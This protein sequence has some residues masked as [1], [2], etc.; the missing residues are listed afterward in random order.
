[1]VRPQWEVSTVAYHK[2]AVTRVVTQHVVDLR[3]RPPIIAYSMLVG[4]HGEESHIGC[5]QEKMCII[6]IRKYSES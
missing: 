1:M 6:F 2:A 5:W 3:L 4:N